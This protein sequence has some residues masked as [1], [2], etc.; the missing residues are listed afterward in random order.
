MA[1]RVYY[2][3]ILKSLKDKTFYKGLTNDLDRRLREHFDG[4][5][6]TTASRRPLILVYVHHCGSRQDARMWEK[7]FKTGVGREVIKELDRIG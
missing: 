1:D 6:Q 4:E 5:C 3:Y 7:F 2:V